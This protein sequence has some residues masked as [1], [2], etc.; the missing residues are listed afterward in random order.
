M[1]TYKIQKDGDF[2]IKESPEG[3]WNDLLLPF[4]DFL[5]I[6]LSN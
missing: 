2:Q 3:D 4:M 5:V 6:V 1:T